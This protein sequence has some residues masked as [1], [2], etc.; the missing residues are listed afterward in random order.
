MNIFKKFNQ[1]QD[2]DKSLPTDPNDLFYSLKKKYLRG[3]QEE[4]LSEWNNRRGEDYLLIKMN[5]T[6]MK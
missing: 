6:L 4:V 2:T 1:D 5:T 3:I